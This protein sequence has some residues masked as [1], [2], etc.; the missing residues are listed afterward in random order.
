[1]M[2]KTL[3]CGLM[4]LLPC[5]LLGQDREIAPDVLQTYEARKALFRDQNLGVK[6]TKRVAVLWGPVP[7]AEI[8]GRAVS[9]LEKLPGLVA[10]R[11]ELDID[12]ELNQAPLFLPET[13]PQE[14]RLPK[15]SQAP[16]ATLT[17]R[18]L[19]KDD[20]REKKAGG[21]SSAGF[22]AVALPATPIPGMPDHREIE[23][24]LPSLRIPTVEPEI[25]RTPEEAIAA[26]QKDG[27]FAPIQVR[28]QAGLATVSAAADI[29]QNLHEFARLISRIQG[30]DRVVVQE[31]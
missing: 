21:Q 15:S 3:T 10:V 27:R 4:L 6:V 24:V 1:M 16:A 26:L 11:N 29:S 12:P 5:P 17:T 7:S 22:G 31:R 30:I 18:S 23:I 8:A 13:L 9:L 14:S 20:V 25:H 28:L 2:C 19:E